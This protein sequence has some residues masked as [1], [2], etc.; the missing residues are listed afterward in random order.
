M[1][2]WNVEDKFGM[3]AS[4]I[5]LKHFFYPGSMETMVQYTTVRNKKSAFVNLYHA[6]VD[7]QGNAIVGGR[8]GKLFLFGRPHLFGFL[9]PFPNWNA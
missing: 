6:Y 1:E 8:Y 4:L 7:N 3:G 5:L 9:W 2:P